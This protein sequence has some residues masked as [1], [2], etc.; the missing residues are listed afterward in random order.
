[1]G[2]VGIWEGSL[3]CEFV[4]GSMCAEGLVMGG[5]GLSKYFGEQRLPVGIQE[6]LKIISPL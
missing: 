1:M 2:G 3:G 4:R 6:C 5:G